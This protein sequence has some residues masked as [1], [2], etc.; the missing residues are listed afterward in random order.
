M[1]CNPLPGAARGLS[2]VVTAMALCASAGCTQR[3]YDGPERAAISGTVTLDGTPVTV[4]TV[5]LM[6]QGATEQNKNAPRISGA[7]ITDG[8][9]AEIEER[10]PN[11]GAYTIAFFLGKPTGK[12]RG[13][14]ESGTPYDEIL[15]DLTP[16]SLKQ[17]VSETPV[18][19]QSGE[20][21]LDIAI[22]KAGEI[23]ITRVGA[24]E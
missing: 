13:V 19:I 3:D 8:K 9:F 22:T 5:Y 18:E 2:L 23:T 14:D 15:Q 6:P 24:A 11:L 21:V 1:W 4:G 20:N 17:G 7:T 12:Y 16:K 10:G